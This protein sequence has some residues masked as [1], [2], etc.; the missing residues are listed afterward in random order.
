M[1]IRINTDNNEIEISDVA[2]ED[3]LHDLLIAVQKLSGEKATGEAK[4]QAKKQTEYI[5]KNVDA[6]KNLSLSLKDWSGNFDDTMEDLDKSMTSRGK[7]IASAL[8]NIVKNTGNVISDLIRG[9][10]S[11]DTLGRAI[12][13]GATAL[14]DGLGG[15]ADSFQVLGTKLPMVGSGIK[16]L[17]AAAG[18]AAMAVAAYAQNLMDGFV[19]LSQSGANYNSDIIR[20]SAQIHGLGL[21]MNAFTQIVQTNA[22]GLAQFGGSVSLGA[23][24]FVELASV[25]RSDYGGSLYAL[26][27]TYDEQA[28][29]LAKYT[30]TQSRNTAFQNM[31]YQQQSV[32]FKDYI[33]DLNT[34]V[35]L[36]GKS[37]QQL[38]QELAQND[39]RADANIRLQGATVEAQK[40]LQLVFSTA[41]Q[42]S[43]ISQ[44]LLAGVAGKDLALEMAA[45]NQT[46]KSFVAGNS[47]AAQ[48]LR[49]LGDAVATGTIDQDEFKEGIRAILPS[50]AQS[51]KEFEGLYGISDV[52][53]VM[54]QAAS[55]VQK[56]Q[57]QFQ[58]L[59]KAVGD[60]DSKSADGVG[61]QILL[62]AATL[63]DF[64]NQ[65]QSGIE[66]GI[67]DWSASLFPEDER[68]I[69]EIIQSRMDSLS[70]WGDKLQTQLDKILTSFTNFFTQFEIVAKAP[71]DW[72]MGGTSTKELRKQA[73]QIVE[74]RG[75]YDS[76]GMEGVMSGAE[77]QTAI[78]KM[79]GPELHA[80]MNALKF[81]S[82]T[83]DG[84]VSEKGIIHYIQ[85]LRS[86][87]AMA[88]ANELSASSTSLAPGV[89]DHAFGS[90][91]EL[92]KSLNTGFKGKQTI[93]LGGG[94]STIIDR[95]P[96]VKSQLAK[97]YNAGQGDIADAAFEQFKQFLHST[98][99]GYKMGMTWESYMQDNNIDGYSVTAAQSVIRD[100]LHAIQRWNTGK[101][102]GQGTDG[103]ALVSAKKLQY[104]GYTS[105]IIPQIINE[106][107]MGEWFTPNTAG[108]MTP[109]SELAT[110]SG[111]MGVISNIQE[112]NRLL[113]QVIKLAS[114]GNQ[115]SE[116]FGST[117]IN[118]S[119]DISKTNTKMLRAYSDINT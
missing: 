58:N 60:S 28:E 57:V 81:D 40:A 9:P 113:G 90:F 23:K 29:Q 41:G 85:S 86:L 46:I 1:A 30:Q 17:G 33:S 87:S 50:I 76:Y 71:W 8:G 45:G 73:N 96:Q 12:Q 25:M 64:Q 59:G 24:R 43:A 102:P 78:S 62:M 6:T 118:I 108:T 52:A 49:D 63:T 54:T 80:A 51:G 67:S 53:T 27:L 69:G 99:P 15:M 93:D 5:K 37:R 21:T 38:A 31:S 42:D 89:T 84:K 47:E 115:L 39:L 92:V 13:S 61:G 112:S 98:I 10:A 44:I 4:S 70:V 35:G 16:M 32:L 107:G 36:T 48:K 7:A 72:L 103:G 75:G 119:K 74:G 109:N 11:F 111:T 18:A 77:I 56:L 91:E 83:A 95:I 14:G 20:T 26:G 79:S 3:T 106:G 55:D 65:I 104:G 94:H 110:A 105:P 68:P 117:S 88:Q 34:L 100:K 66:G 2:T 82:S 116:A 114:Q 19:A 101:F 97:A 22:Q